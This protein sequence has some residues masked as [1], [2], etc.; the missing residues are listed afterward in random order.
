MPDLL[1]EEQNSEQASTEYGQLALRPRSDK[2]DDGQ[3]Q[4]AGATEKAAKKR[5]RR[6]KRAEHPRVFLARR[7]A[8]RAAG[9]ETNKNATTTTTTTTMT[10]ADLTPQRRSA[11][12]QRTKTQQER[13]EELISSQLETA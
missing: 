6:Q 2:M 7:Q 8:E 4:Q 13:D 3:P 12:L 1:D 9:L 5:S 11:R 10:P